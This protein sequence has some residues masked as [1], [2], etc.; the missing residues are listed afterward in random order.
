MAAFG[1]V[2]RQQRLLSLL[3]EALKWC[4]VCFLVPDPVEPSNLRVDT[5]V[6][7]AKLFL[8]RREMY[9][10]CLGPWLTSG[11]SWSCGKCRT[12]TNGTELESF[13]AMPVIKTWQRCNQSKH[14]VPN[15]LMSEVTTESASQG[16]Q[17]Q[18]FAQIGSIS[19]K[20][21]FYKLTKK[22]KKTCY[23]HL[24]IP[25]RS[26]DGVAMAVRVLTHKF[27][28]L[29]ARSWCRDGRCITMILGSG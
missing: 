7:E 24:F 28:R 8:N 22:N 25:E 18:T 2:D 13:P 14:K 20:I 11:L 21:E 5:A 19:I 4:L 27:L 12:H 29:K 3:N 26:L 1:F 16:K 10:I 15:L 23:L 6:E 9:H 17:A